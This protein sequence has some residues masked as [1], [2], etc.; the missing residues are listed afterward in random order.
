M[1]PYYLFIFNKENPLAL[2]YVMCARGKVLY[3]VLILHVL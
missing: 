1:F 3:Y 2:I